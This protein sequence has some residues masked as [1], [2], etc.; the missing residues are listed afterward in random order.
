MIISDNCFVGE[1]IRNPQKLL[2]KLNKGIVLKNFCFIA[3]VNGGN[4]L[5]ILGSV[6]FNQKYFKKQNYEIVALVNSQDDAFE[7]IRVLS[8]L[9]VRAFGEFD[10]RRTVEK[11]PA[12][13]IKSTMESEGV[14]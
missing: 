14:S 13:V 12:S 4:R 3:F 5:E 8:E 11:F 6:L 7:Y 2:N 10:A 1:D 9:S